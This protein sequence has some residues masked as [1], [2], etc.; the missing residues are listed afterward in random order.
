MTSSYPF[1][2][3][4]VTVTITGLTNPV[5]TYGGLVAAKEWLGAESTPGPV[6]WM[7]LATDS[8]KSKRLVDATRY[9]DQLSWRT[10]DDTEA[11]A[12]AVAIVTATFELAGLITI[13]NETTAAVDAGSNI[14]SLSAKAGTSIEFFRPTSA[15]DGTAS[16]LP[17]IIQ[18]LIGKYLAS[19][20][21]S[22]A[23]AAAGISTGT[24]ENSHFEDCDALSLTRGY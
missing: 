1:G 20:D 23:A 9:L 4:V 6:A 11:A 21:P 16:T 19:S 14:K 22:I 2:A 13:D 7:A 5:S 12:A 17:V 10:I 3:S 15:L 24:T 8:E 18:R